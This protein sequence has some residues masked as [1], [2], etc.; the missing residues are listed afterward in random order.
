MLAAAAAAAADDDDDDDGGDG[1]DDDIDDDT[2]DDE[3]KGRIVWPFA[4]A[5]FGGI[6]VA[7]SL[8][9]GIKA[10]NSLS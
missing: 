5:V 1:G 2:D 4:K 7:I 10:L 6:A 3:L 8:E 9:K